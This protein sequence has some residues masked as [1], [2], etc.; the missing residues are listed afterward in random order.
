MSKLPSKYNSTISNKNDINELSKSRII[1]NNLVYII[2]LS[3]NIS[4]RD[5]LLKNE[6]LGQ[7]GT[8]KK[9][10]INKKKAYNLNNRYGPS[11]SAYVTY[12]EP[13]EASIAILV[14]DNIQV[15]N[16]LIRAS[17]GTTKYC[18]YFLKGK[19]CTNKDC[20]YLHKKASDNNIIRREDLNVNKNIFYEQ[21]IYAIKIADIY[22]PIVKNNLMN[23]SQMK[24]TVFPSPA[25]IYQNSIVIEN[26]KYLNIYKNKKN[27]KFIH[28]NLKGIKTNEKREN[29]HMIKKIFSEDSRE[30]EKSQSELK[31]NNQKNNTRNNNTNLKLKIDFISNS[32]DEITCPSTGDEKDKTLIL[33]QN[34]EKSRFDFVE[35]G[36]EEINDIPQVYVDIINEKYKFKNIEHY[37]KNA[38]LILF[39]NTQIQND[40]KNNKECYNY[41]INENNVLELEKDEFERDFENINNFVL[42]QTSKI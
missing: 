12:S 35:N 27:L 23:I 19:E 32:K 5:I 7:Y 41:L 33:L 11:Y 38:D 31:Q 4:S 29:N 42:E 1:T 2:G 3:E 16:H 9:L 21:Q 24:N 25:L 10:V 8:I 28:S 39:N 13:Y 26:E 37:F 14:L 6:Y 34:K 40:I 36:S 18:Q 30:E 15:D 22:N 17:F 20:L